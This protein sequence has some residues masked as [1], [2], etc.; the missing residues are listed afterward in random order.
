MNK[1]KHIDTHIALANSLRFKL[2]AIVGENINKKNKIIEYLKSQGYT[3]IDVASE[4]GPLYESLLVS[5]E[6]SC[7]IVL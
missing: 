5:N 1:E 4:L 2:W 3:L 7:Q 6:T